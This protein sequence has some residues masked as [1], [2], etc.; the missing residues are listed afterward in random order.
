MTE[1]RESTAARLAGAVVGIALVGVV[2]WLTGTELRVFPLYFLPIS[3]GSWTSKRRGAFALA[4]L[5]TAAWMSSNVAVGVAHPGTFAFNSVMQ[6]TS[7][8]LVAVLIAELHRRLQREREAS[9]VDPLTGLHNRRAFLEQ[10]EIV[11]QIA[12]RHPRPTT[13]AY[14]DLD[15]FKQVNDTHGH[16]VGDEVL[17]AVATQIRDRVRSADVVAR[18]GGDELAILLP[19]T[20]EDG[21]REVLE[22]VR[23]GVADA[24]HA[25]GWPVTT[26]IGAVTVVGAPPPLAELLTRS[27]AQMYAAKSEGRDRVHVETW[28]VSQT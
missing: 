9:R 20:D 11:L 4:G 7:F 5:A 8:V 3:L 23:R 26:S 19:E 10:A 15:H 6:A 16:D 1:L 18:L 14:V 25:K 17:R 12:R 13:L 22:R 24:M 2:D 27:D 21:A 28:D